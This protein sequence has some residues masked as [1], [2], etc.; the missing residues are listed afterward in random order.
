MLM[1]ITN[2]GMGGGVASSGSVTTTYYTRHRNTRRVYPYVA[3]IL[4]V[5][6]G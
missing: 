5:I 4:A 1:W 6:C 3:A 2:L